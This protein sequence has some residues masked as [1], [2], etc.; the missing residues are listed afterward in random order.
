[1][2][3]VE[4]LETMV[5]MFSMRKAYTQA[6]KYSLEFCGKGLSQVTSAMMLC[7]VFIRKNLKK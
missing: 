1:M 5:R 4:G 3:R 7:C 2:G 6:R